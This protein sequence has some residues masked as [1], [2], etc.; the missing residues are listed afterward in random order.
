MFPQNEQ[1]GTRAHSP[2]PSFYETALL[3]PGELQWE[4]IPSEFFSVIIKMRAFCLCNSL[5]R[6]HLQIRSGEV[7][8][9]FSLC[10][11]LAVTDVGKCQ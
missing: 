1:P 8:V 7:P 2:K 9:S 10:L 4:I 3:S 6:R 5:A 11:K